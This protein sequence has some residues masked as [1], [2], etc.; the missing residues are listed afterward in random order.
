MKHHIGWTNVLLLASTVYVQANEIQEK[1]TLTE[2]TVI[3]ENMYTPNIGEA[4]KISLIP[5]IP[6][7]KS[8]KK[9][10][11]YETQAPV[12][13]GEFPTYTTGS[14]GDIPTTPYKRN[15]GY[16]RAGYGNRGNLDSRLHYRATLDE[17]DVLEADVRLYGMNG[18]IKTPAAGGTWK[19][20]TYQ[21]HAQADWKHRWER[22]EMNMAAGGKSHVF[23]YWN[24][25]SVSQGRQN[26][27]TGFAQISANNLL[28]E[29]PVTFKAGTTL[30]YARQKYATDGKNPSEVHLHTEGNFNLKMGEGAHITFGLEMDNLFYSIPDKLPEMKNYTSIGLNPAYTLE[31]NGWKARL[32]IHADIQT[33][34]GKTLQLAPD[35]KGEYRLGKKSA[36]QLD[37]NG[38]RTINDF[39]RQAILNPYIPYF[40]PSL[41]WNKTQQPKNSYTYVNIMGGWK[42]TPTDGFTLNAYAGY[43]LTKDQLFG[44]TNPQTSYNTFTQDDANRV[45]V[46]IGAR[47]NYRHLLSTQ[48]KWQWERWD[49]E[50]IDNY[51]TLL[52][53]MSLNWSATF[54]PIEELHIGLAYTYTRRSKTAEDWRP[55]AVNNLGANVSYNLLQGLTI[56]IKGD[57]LLAQTYFDHVACPAQGFN[58]MAGAALDF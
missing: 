45:Y 53:E 5:P 17:R 19:A 28:E 46:G 33:A 4:K 32:G 15:H 13:G 51:I 52:P 38:G 37:I 50:V 39:H 49:S 23:N 2:R 1:D 58:L 57:N 40:Q 36:L 55:E 41:P 11:S 43:Q 34:H 56:Y 47:Y 24:T 22:W 31:K 3:V 30:L 20:R 29:T 18:D 21:T 42:M 6:E 27:L 9:Q 16:L 12:F 8:E 14:K 25:P 48:L 7:I 10:V 35:I 54:N 44:T 26:I